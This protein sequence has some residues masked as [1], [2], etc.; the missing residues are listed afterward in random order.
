MRR[1]DCLLCLLAAL[2][3]L[4]ALPV[5]AAEPERRLTVVTWGGAYEAAQRV[6]VFAPFTAATGIEIEIARYDGGLE[7]LRRETDKPGG[8]DWDVI[9]MVRADAEAGCATG[10]L[11]PFDPSGLAPAPDGTPAH[12]DFI[13]GAFGDCAVTQLVFATVIAYDDRAF[14]G[15]KPDSVADFFDLE[16]FPGRRGLRKTPVGML[17]WALRAYG[18]PRSQIYDL[19]STE[20]GLALAS[21]RLD[22][23]RDEIVWWRGGSEPVE[24]LKRGEVAMATGYNGRFFQAQVVDGAPISIIWDSALL[25]DNTWAIPKGTADRDLAERFLRFATASEQLAAM[26]N[27]ISYGPARFSAQRRIGLHEA[28]GIPMR[29]HLPTAPRHLSQALRKDDAWY[30]R[31]TELRRRWFENWLAEEDVGEMPAE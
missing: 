27:R 14:P 31:T 1:H 18:V 15:E 21:R 7:D 22:S 20:R 5:P 29:P 26:S 8:P 25:E 24:M 30:A 6:A 9:D 28:S 3:A 13:A 2:T 19:L 4:L 11:A 16:R 23:I 17:D 12:E 10:L